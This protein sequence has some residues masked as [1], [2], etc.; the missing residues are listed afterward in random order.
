MRKRLVFIVSALLVVLVLGYFGGGYVVYDQLSTIDPPEVETLANTPASFKVTYEEYADFDP[1][2]YLMSSYETV[3]FSSRQSDINL[4]GWYIEVDPSAPVIVVTHGLGSSKKSANL[5]TPAG[6]LSHHGF[7][8]LIYDLRNHGES[9]HDNGRTSIGN[10]E[11]QDVLG[12]WDWLV[13]KK[14][15]SAEQIGMYGVSLGG[16]TTLVAFGE[17]SQMAAAF[18]DSPFANLPEIMNAELARNNYPTFLT[19]PAVIMA[20]VVAGEDLLAHTPMDAI[21]KDNGRPLYIV[22]GTGDE[23]ISVNQTRELEALARE[24]NAN[25]TT[26]IPE[27]VGHVEGVFEFPE[28]YEQRMVS[29]FSEALK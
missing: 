29:F 27:G 12:A 6:M 7:N 21:Y 23:R 28:E 1:S 13:S 11:F 9:D 2:P 4:S 22:H 16:G 25:L 15:Y 26:W 14:G 8:I 18:I 17:E 19:T 5:L 20:R 24:T 3:N 10:K